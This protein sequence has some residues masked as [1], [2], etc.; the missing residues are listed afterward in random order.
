MA[1]QF[2]AEAPYD[3]SAGTS[4]GGRHHQPIVVTREDDEA[5]PQLYSALWNNEALESVVIEVVD[6]RPSG[7][8]IV[9]E[10]ITLTDAQIVDAT[11]HLGRGFKPSKRLMDFTFI[12][13]SLRETMW[14]G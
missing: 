4:S 14:R 1:F 9:A 3:P 5:S 11:L 12:E 10:T 2:G 13:R 6:Q 8:E 7:H